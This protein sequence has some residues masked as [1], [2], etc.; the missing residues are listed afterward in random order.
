MARSRKTCLRCGRCG[1]ASEKWPG[2]LLRMKFTGE[3][4]SDFA[5]ESLSPR[6]P[7]AQLYPPH[8][9]TTNVIESHP[10]IAK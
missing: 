5:N 2:L 6:A 1:D 10:A 9:Q 4:N 8:R 7:K 3:T